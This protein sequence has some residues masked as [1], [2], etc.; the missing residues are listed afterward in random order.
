MSPFTS[1]GT[2]PV[3]IVVKSGGRFV[4][5]VNQGAPAVGTAPAVAGNIAAFSVGNDGV[6]TFQQSL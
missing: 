6:L 4:Y 3:S 5:V 2:N 1:G